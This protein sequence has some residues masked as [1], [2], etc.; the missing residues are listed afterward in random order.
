MSLLKH[1][2]PDPAPAAGK[3]AAARI[4]AG[5]GY[6]IGY[7][8]IRA[9]I[10]FLP[11]AAQV[12]AGYSTGSGDVPWTEADFAAHGTELGPCLRIC[13]DS[14]ASDPA[15]DYADYENGTM[16]LARLPGWVREARESY[17]AGR[18]P[19]QRWPGIYQSASNVTP[20][21]NE[22]TGAGITS[23]VPL[24]VAEWSL[25]EPQAIQDVLDAAGP[26]PVA[27]I[28]FTDHGP[29]DVNIFSL[30]WLRSQSAKAVPASQ[31]AGKP[32]PAPAQPPAD[33]R[34]FLALL[35]ALKAGDKDTAEPWM[36]RRVQ[37]LVNALGPDCPV[38][39]VFD[40]ATQ[41]A[42]KAF[43]ANHGVAASGSVD[44]ATWSML[45][46]GRVL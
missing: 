29:F 17:R 8:A 27:G 25:T 4:L 40:E 44:A 22:L 10:P 24:I 38:T 19:G 12:Y 36:V 33:W 9:G 21:V 34:A 39:G 26:F 31:P 15:A 6:A 37:G 14:G 28:Q 41:A 2:K 30:E 7:D 42:V 13:Q 43:Q 16:P 18:R 3:P 20:V 35:P 1:K 32:A 5:P 11:K 23:G 45:L 46:S